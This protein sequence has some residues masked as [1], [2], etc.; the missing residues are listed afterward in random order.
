M[1]PLIVADVPPKPATKAAAFSARAI[2]FVAEA[3]NPA[4]DSMKA[5]REPP[6]LDAG[7]LYF[8]TEAMK[9]G[10]AEG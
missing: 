5:A 2:T 9:K 7:A 10:A 6:C 3:V 1:Q 8:T 4:A